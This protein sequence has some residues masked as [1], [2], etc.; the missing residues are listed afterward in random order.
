MKKYITCTLL[1]I[2]SFLI[3]TKN[4]YAIIGT[5][6][7]VGGEYSTGITW[8]SKGNGAGEC[9]AYTDHKKVLKINGEKYDSEFSLFTILQQ[10]PHSYYIC[11]L[12]YGSNL[13]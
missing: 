4:A 12:F 6:E 11:T 9:R 7:F 1:L 13:T 10:T 8:C 3:G 5:A 2:L